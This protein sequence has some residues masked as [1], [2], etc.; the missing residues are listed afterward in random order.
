MSTATDHPNSPEKKRKKDNRSSRK[1]NSTPEQKAKAHDFSDALLGAPQ[2]VQAYGEATGR[3]K[4]QREESAAD[5][6]TGA[7]AGAGREE[8]PKKKRKD[9]HEQLNPT[10][11]VTRIH[12]PNGHLPQDRPSKQAPNSQLIPTQTQRDFTEEPTRRIHQSPQAEPS[13]D[14][15]QAKDTPRSAQAGAVPGLPADLESPFVSV[16]ASFKVTVPPVAQLYPL[17]GALANYISPLLLTWHP[18]LDGILLAYNNGRLHTTPPRGTEDKREEEQ[19][20]AQAVDECAA[21]YVWLTLDAL[22]FKPKK[23]LE[24]EGYLNLQNESHITLILW[25]FFT[26]TISQ[27]RLPKGWVW[28]DYYGEDAG[29]SDLEDKPMRRTDEQWGAWHNGQGNEIQ[30]FLRFRIKNWDCAPPGSSGEGSF[31]SIEGTMLTDE[32]EEELRRELVEEARQRREL[33]ATSKRRTPLPSALRK[34][35]TPAQEK[36]NGASSEQMP[37]AIKKTKKNAKS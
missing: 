14:R 16:S 33:S 28:H 34:I 27:K 13:S 7:G 10:S 20:K 35:T 22:V 37:T 11:L 12:P 4:R 6:A 18:Q 25:N 29:T 21:P 26:V 8:S 3:K 23:G 2:P 19:P 5:A 32:E 36:V 9:A 31:L 30:G 17:E 24:L 15:S 1:S